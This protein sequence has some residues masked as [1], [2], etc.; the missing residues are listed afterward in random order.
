MN[1]NIF[2]CGG[3]RIL[4]LLCLFLSTGRAQ[5]DTLKGRVVD[6][7]T[8]EPL[9]GAEVIVQEES[10]GAGRS[11]MSKTSLAADSLGRFEYTCW[12]ELSKLTITA[13]YFGYHS[14]TTGRTGSNDRDTITIDDLRLRMDEHLL[15]E[16]TVEGRQRRFYMRGD[17]VVFNPEAFNTQDGARLI[18]LIEQLPGVT[19]N[20][21]KLLWNGEPLRL[22]M[23]GQEAISEGLLTN[24]LPV[25][26]V[27][28]I[29]AY[30][31]KSD[32]EARTGVADGQEEHVLD[33]TIKP[34]FMDKF[35]GDA[36]AKAYTRANYA[37]HLRTMRLSDNNP[38]LLYGRVADDPMVV[39]VTKINGSSLAVGSVPIRQ[40][41]GAVG[42]SHR[43]KPAFEAQRPSH[44][45]INGGA[46]HT[47]RRT[48]SWE[49]RQTFLP[50]SSSALASNSSSAFASG[51][52]PAGS[53]AT[54]IASDYRHDLKVPID[55]ESFLNL[56]ANTTLDIEANITYER[57]RNVAENKQ[58]T[59]RLDV[60]DTMLNTSD[61]HSL[62]MGEGF[63][64][65][66]KGRLSSLL[67]RTELS[68]KTSLSYDNTTSDGQ[69]TGIYHYF[70]VPS[71]ATLSQQLPYTS[72]QQLPHI[73]RQHFH[74]P[75]RNFTADASLQARRALGQRLT[76]VARW[77]TIYTHRFRDERRHRADT[78]DT[79]NSLRR[80][81]NTWQNVLHLDANLTLGKFSAKPQLDFTHFHEQTD[82]LRGHLDTLAN[83]NQLFVRPA[84]ELIYKFQK[85][86]RLRG[87]VTYSSQLPGIL[88]CIGYRDDTNPLYITLGNPYLKSSHT[89]SGDLTFSRLFTKDGQVLAASMNLRKD[90]API[91]TVLH[92]NS[93]TGGYQAQKQNLRGGLRWGGSI[94]YERELAE[95]LHIKNEL[96]ESLGQAYGIMTLVDDA[97]NI[98][99]S[100]SASR[101]YP[102]GLENRQRS[103][104]LTERLT[105]DY[106]S[107]PLSLRLNQNF[108]WHSYTYSAS[109]QP[110]QSIINYRADL[111]AEYVLKSWTF[112]LRPTFRLDRGYIA[113]AMNINRLLCNASISY[114]LLKNKARLTLAANDLLNRDSRYHSDVTATTRTEGGSTFLH[115]YV[116]L[117]FNYTFDAKTR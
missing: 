89:L 30:D 44:W 11:Y 2:R 110:R 14:L 7:D 5:A 9:S 47:D 43:W 39:N 66:L 54:R 13:N 41:T 12:M 80:R 114:S 73:D 99:Y 90:Y 38:L 15:S 1:L 97:T 77:Q 46:N 98:T 85:Q 113:E 101:S 59:Y 26:A 53:S 104:V 45:S 88:D 74:A 48:D 103:S 81:D 96:A 21:G 63:S 27:K 107:G 24:L 79:A 16:V 86:T 35:Y 94:T 100:S 92:F 22:M 68:A 40:Q 69:S 36:E 76:L 115:H 4:P 10:V 57:K 31:R 60:P 102:E 65:G 61:F 58:Q 70:N 6:A 28:D 17:T 32:F 82:Y 112:Q 29:K 91:G 55:F 23:N 34:G 116:S 8:G 49:N 109:A 50:G 56:T 51:G 18:E 111:T 105:L 72:S 78:L 108:T 71:V 93:H 84:L 75:A 87:N 37:A 42:Y 83:R 106:N 117:T 95:H 3:L 62:A 25:E 64:T 52:F 20:D 19:V 67:G 33:V